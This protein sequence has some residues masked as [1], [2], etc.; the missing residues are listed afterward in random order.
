MNKLARTGLSIAAFA[1]VAAA[2]AGPAQADWYSFPGPGTQVRYVFISDVSTN[3]VSWVGSDNLPHT[4]TAKFTMRRP[5]GKFW[6]Q[7]VITLSG[8]NPVLGSA[9]TSSGG[10]AECK[11][12]VGGQQQKNAILAGPR[13][14]VAC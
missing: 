12:I 1:A 8:S 14:T 2:A 3:S 9:V 5:D 10:Y 7:R 6:T 11:V 13:A 4:Q